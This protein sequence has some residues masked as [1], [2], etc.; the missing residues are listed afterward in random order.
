LKGLPDFQDWLAP[1][2]PV[3]LGPFAGEGFHTV[4]PDGLA[5]AERA[6]GRPDLVLDLVRGQDAM[7]GPAAHGML[8]LRLAGSY[9]LEDA[10][11]AARARSETAT[12]RRAAFSDGV[13]WLKPLDPG[14]DVAVELISAASLAG[15]G[16]EA[17]RWVI[18]LSAEGAS[19]VKRALLEKVL[20]VQ[21][22]AQLELEGIAP[23]VETKVRF[24][25][26]ALREA[27]AAMA[28]ASGLVGRDGLLAELRAK[29]GSLP[30][31]F[32][33]ELGTDVREAL[34]QALVDLLVAEIAEL[35]PADDH[36]EPQLAPL[37][38]EQLAEGRVE[39]D[40]RKPFVTR[41]PLVLDLD[42]ITAVREYIDAHGAD[43]VVHES[44]VP[45]LATGAQTIDL[46]ANLPAGR[47]GVLSIGADVLALPSLPFRPQAI[48]RS[49]EFVEPSDT[50]SVQLVLGPTEQLA[51]RCT[52]TAVLI[53]GAGVR[54]LKGDA[55]PS[56]S[57]F[58]R[59]D[60]DDFPAVFVHVG[61]SVGLLG[62]AT[63]EGT[64]HRFSAQGPV[65][66]AF[67]LTAAQPAVALALPRDAEGASLE[68]R[69]VPPNG[70][71][72]VV[73]GPL[74][75]ADLQLD[76]HSFSG[77]GPHRVHVEC[78]FPDGVADL[79]VDLVPEARA[80]EPS[81]L[82]LVHLT[83]EQPAADWSWFADS[84]FA[85]GYRFRLHPRPGEQPD[86]WSEAQSPSEPLL[87]TA[88]DAR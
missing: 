16:L 58:L 24:D 7:V 78:N 27:L 67:K 59:L 66:Q 85:P 40:L 2:D 55:Q 11:A 42:P 52:P 6:D 54:Q 47:V 31:E 44:A 51:Y 56:E 12:V 72:P 68:I 76:L 17:A 8:E 70:G 73:L 62:Q 50:A 84:P 83:P 46:A 22:R 80:E 19:L 74:P 35:A 21:A 61:G 25:P 36:G 48:L 71:P 81:A 69:A 13:L 14:S 41:R 3:V 32:L 5:L 88:G 87:L 26:R 28:G 63:V 57:T 39:R 4:L 64:L 10:L 43:E 37:A 30:F 29:P 20:T 60:V 15:T 33:P 34:A 45:T 23:R 38:V 53:E 49:V 9:R 86:P 65:A 75:A 1:S 77:Y 82:G 18:E 79:A